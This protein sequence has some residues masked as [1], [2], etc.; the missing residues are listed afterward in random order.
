M[1]YPGSIK[2]SHFE[3]HNKHPWKITKWD[4]NRNCP[5]RSQYQTSHLWQV[6]GRGGTLSFFSSF[7]SSLAG[8]I[9][10]KAA[11][12]LHFL[13]FL[14]MTAGSASPTSVALF[15]D[16]SSTMEFM[17]SIAA[18]DFITLFLHFEHNKSTDTTVFCKKNKKQN[19]TTLAGSK[20]GIYPRERVQRES[21]I[22]KKKA[23]CLEKEEYS[24]YTW[25]NL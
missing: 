24:V 17:P 25:N 18:I 8:P 19:F 11:D 2:E 22:Q 9:L 6:F 7:F 12:L 13:S 3:F 14:R 1:H 5:P 10:T 4:S 23:N 21:K 16:G 15:F 20:L